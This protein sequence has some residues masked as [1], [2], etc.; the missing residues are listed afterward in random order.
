MT[1]TVIVELLK[2]NQKNLFFFTDSH[3]SG[4]MAIRIKLR[5]CFAFGKNKPATAIRERTRCGCVR[6][7]HIGE[8]LG[9]RE[10]QPAQPKRQ[11]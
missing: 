6:I 1:F 5:K 9:E 11:P 4:C 8:E 2:L 10:G 7:R 3:W